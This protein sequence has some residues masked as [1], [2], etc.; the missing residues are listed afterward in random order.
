M[1]LCIYSASAIASK[2]SEESFQVFKLMMDGVENERATWKKK[3]DDVQYL[4]RQASNVSIYIII[5]ILSRLK[6]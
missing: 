5:Y 3:L 1:S 2:A 4:L 6:Y